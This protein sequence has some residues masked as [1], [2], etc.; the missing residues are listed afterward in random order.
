MPAQAEYDLLA[1]DLDGT[2]LDTQHRLPDRNRAALHAAHE[3]GLRVVVCTGRCYTETRPI[4]DRIGLDL[5]AAITVGGALLTEVATG[6]TLQSTQIALDLALTA[7]RWFTARDYSVIWLR[8]A[9]EAG[10]DGYLIQAGLRHPAIDR[11]LAITP[12]RMREIAALPTDGMPPLRV[13]VVDD[14]NALDRVSAA[15][16]RQFDG[17]MAFNVIRVPAYGFTVLEAFAAGVDKWFGIT[18]L[19]ARWGVDPART[20]AIGDDVNDLPMIQNAALGVAVANARPEV[21]RAARRQVAANDA[22][23][24]ADLIDEILLAR[25]G[26]P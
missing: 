24:V 15:F 25:G 4:L 8:D 6:K 11:W 7:A 1:I 3:A 10:F 21:R 19:C 23:G 9:R 13:N 16:R 2:L 12:C 14:I 18:Q 22:C 5:D 20:V 26:K 17:R